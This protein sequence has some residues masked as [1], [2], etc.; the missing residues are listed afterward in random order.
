MGNKHP[1]TAV[2]PPGPNPYIHQYDDG[3]IEIILNDTGN[4]FGAGAVVQIGDFMNGWN[5]YVNYMVIA[6]T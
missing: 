2:A 6:N 3:N 4:P 5:D 1:A